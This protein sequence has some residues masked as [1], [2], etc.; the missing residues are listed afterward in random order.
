MRVNVSIRQRTHA[1]GRLEPPL[2]LWLALLLIC[3]APAQSQQTTLPVWQG[4]VRDARG[5]PAVG[6]IVRL[7]RHG[8]KAEAKSGTGGRFRLPPLPA[9]Q[10]SLSIE[11]N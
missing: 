8:T 6:V 2:H 3:T 11:A 1:I 9:G 10:Y 4:V 5:A 7:T